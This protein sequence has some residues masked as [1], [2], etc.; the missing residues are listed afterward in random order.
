MNLKV[1]M[2]GRV[3]PLVIPN[4]QVVAPTGLWLLVQTKAPNVLRYYFSPDSVEYTQ[5]IPE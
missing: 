1:Y 4:V 2:K 3:D 5:H